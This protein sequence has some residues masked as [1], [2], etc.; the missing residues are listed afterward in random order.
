MLGKSFELNSIVCGY[1]GS[2][3]I[4]KCNADKGNRRNEQYK[5]GSEKRN[6]KRAMQIEPR[7]LLNKLKPNMG[8]TISVNMHVIVKWPCFYSVKVEESYLD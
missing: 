3:A 2:N 7:E 6:L 8:S 1:N 4:Q 5:Q